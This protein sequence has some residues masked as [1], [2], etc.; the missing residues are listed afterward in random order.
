M[1]KILIFP[2]QI[3]F[4]ACII[5]FIHLE[6]YV[7]TMQENRFRE[8][9]LLKKQRSCYIKRNLLLFSEWTRENL[10]VSRVF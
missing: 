4:Y 2:K 9:K 10:G 6:S 7:R 8:T 1:L 3:I 5:S